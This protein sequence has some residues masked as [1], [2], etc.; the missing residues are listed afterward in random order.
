MNIWWE[1]CRCCGEEKPD[2][3]ARV[4]DWLPTLHRML[5]RPGASRRGLH[6]RPT[7]G[8]ASMSDPD[9]KTPETC[10]TCHVCQRQQPCPLHPR[11]CAVTA[12]I[13]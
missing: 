8:V 1:K 9:C 11:D 12:T 4:K 5:D 10:G 2:V 7:K 6:P 3:K 13:L